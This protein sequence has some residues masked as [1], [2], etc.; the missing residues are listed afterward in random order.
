MVMDRNGHSHKAAGRPDGGQYETKTGMGSDMDLTGEYKPGM[1]K[2]ADLRTI[3][4]HPETLSVEDWHTLRH[5]PHWVVR[6]HAW[7]SPQSPKLDDASFADLMEDDN[8]RVRHAVSWRDDLTERQA[9]ALLKDGIPYVRAGAILCSNLSAKDV[10]DTARFDQNTIV[11]ETARLRCEP[12]VRSDDGR[13]ARNAIYGPVNTSDGTIMA[14]GMRL[15]VGCR[16]QKAGTDGVRVLLG[17]NTVADIAMVKPSRGLSDY[18]F[19]RTYGQSRPGGTCLDSPRL[20]VQTDHNLNGGGSHITMVLPADTDLT[21]DDVDDMAY[22]LQVETRGWLAGY[23]DD[24]W[25][26]ASTSEDGVKGFSCMYV[27]ETTVNVSYRTRKRGGQ[28]DETA[29][30]A[31]QRRMREECDVFSRIVDESDEDGYDW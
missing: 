22:R 30:A 24:D 3:R 5:N 18:M 6:M 15:P 25:S 8:K 28:V 19:R 23:Q 12:A 27:D 20:L 26:D 1:D 7:S 13:R 17:N 4:E 16:W 11:R 10:E 29:S 21:V 2:D 14:G 9:K 31:I